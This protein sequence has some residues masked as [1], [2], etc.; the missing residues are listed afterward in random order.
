MRRANR[1]VTILLVIS[2]TASSCSQGREVSNGAPESSAQVTPAAQGQDAHSAASLPAGG[3]APEGLVSADDVVKRAK[4]ITETLRRADYE[5]AA[6]SDALGPGV[7]PAFQ[8]V[9]DRIGFEPYSGVLRGAE[10]TLASRAG[11]AL[12]R[13]LLLADILARKRI[14]TR[15]VVGQLDASQTERLMSRLFGASDAGSGSGAFAPSPVAFAYDPFL[16]RVYARASRDYAA[17]RAALG[18]SMPATASVPRDELLRELSQ[19]AWVQAERDGRWIDLDPSFPDSVPEQAFGLR[20]GTLDVLPPRL[21]QQ[22]VIRIVVETLSGGSLRR[23]TSLELQ[24]P[25]ADLIDRQIFLVHVPGGGKAGLAGGIEGAALG[26]DAWTPVLSIDGTMRAGE[27]VLM[28][29]QTAEPVRGEQPATGLGGVFR[30]GGALAPPAAPFVAE[31]LEFEILSPDGRR[32]TVSRPLV[33][34]GGEAWRQSLRFDAARL[35]PLPRDADGLLAPRF[36]HNIWFSA[37][38]HDLAAYADA[39]AGFASWARANADKTPPAD[40]PF[41]EALWPFALHNFAFFV[42]SDHAMLPSINESA[43]RRFYA[44]SPRI[45]IAS[46]GPTIRNNAPALRIEYDIR[47]DAIRGVARDVSGEGGVVERKI[48]FGA[49]EGALEHELGE[50]YSAGQIKSDGIVSTSSLL[51]GDGAVALRP[52]DA[53]RTD[54]LFSDAETAALAERD[55][56]SG[57]TL[58]IPRGV[59]RGGP[60]GWWAVAIARAD[61]RA[62]LENGAGG[63][64]NDFNPWGMG[65]GQR[66]GG[67]GAWDASTGQRVGGRYGSARKPD[68]KGGAN[69]YLMM[70]ALG[71]ALVGLGAFLMVRAYNEIWMPTMAAQVQNAVETGMTA[72][73][74][75]R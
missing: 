29:E 27:P 45:L 63:I 74:Q 3:R 39:A 24:L 8:F 11:N 44:D 23:K 30:P 54:S 41:T 55:L 57:A 1:H 31:W 58:V 69:E 19:H 28:T 18:S 40:L 50:R 25:A 62:V 34:R 68:K 35:R 7:E 47:R 53:N 5:L 64:V 65:Q 6:A 36:V 59:F 61:T 4:Q 13:A 49:L 33:D 48:W 71:T 12:D 26:R 75:R 20:A 16:S 43:G 72:D 21:H 46:A 22:V 38:R 52:S 2:L 66:P 51:Q 10:G 17:I 42:L 67:G 15:F 70:I 14:R 56:K 37:S 60:R 9:R 73:R 32:E